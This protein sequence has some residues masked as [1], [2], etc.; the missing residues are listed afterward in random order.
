MVD[1]VLDLNK[2]YKV[3]GWSMEGWDYCLQGGEV[4]GWSESNVRY[5][6]LFTPTR[7]DEEK[8]HDLPTDH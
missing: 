5:E 6:W 3:R 8:F 2:P 7:E 1:R 4:Y